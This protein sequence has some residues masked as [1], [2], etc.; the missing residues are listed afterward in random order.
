MTIRQPVR[1]IKDKVP[2]PTGITISG[3]M[4]FSE[5]EQFKASL[6]LSLGKGFVLPSNYTFISLFKHLDITDVFGGA[7]KNWRMVR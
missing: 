1:Q 6:S 5:R 7:A 2:M 3:T 4:W